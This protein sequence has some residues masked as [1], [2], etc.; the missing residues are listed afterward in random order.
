M[1]DCWNNS[2]TFCALQNVCKRYLQKHAFGYNGSAD[3]LITGKCRRGAECDDE[4]EGGDKQEEEG[5][6]SAPGKT[7]QQ[8]K[9]E[10]LDAHLMLWRVP[11]QL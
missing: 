1:H 5:G 8:E 10:D 6:K 4:E 9:L 3:S 11:A 7:G 2:L